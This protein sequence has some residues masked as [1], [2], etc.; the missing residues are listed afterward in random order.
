MNVSSSSFTRN[1]DGFAR[2][3]AAIV[4]DVLLLDELPGGVDDEALTDFFARPELA[5]LGAWT[6][7]LGASGGRQRAAV[8]TRLPGLEPEPGFADV[9]YPEGTLTE[10]RAAVPERFRAAVDTEGR[11][12]L[13]TAAGWIP[14]LGHDVLFVALDLQSTGWIDSAEDRLRVLQAGTILDVARTALTRRSERMPSSTPTSVVGGDFNLVGS[15]TPLDVLT[16][17]PGATGPRAADPLEPVDAERLGERTLT[18]WQSPGAPFAPGRL[19][20]LLVPARDLSVANAFVFAT[21][22]LPVE[23]LARLGLEAGLSAELSDHLVLVA[24]LTTR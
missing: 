18:T 23:V 9:R 3:F 10:L 21:G 6:F 13:S 7:V 17:I 12:G 8:A 14:V 24:D 22:D 1:A 2:L 19:D 11:S 15:R 20:Y 5:A 4:P 16:Q